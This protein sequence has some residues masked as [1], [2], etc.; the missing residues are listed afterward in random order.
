MKYAYQIS[1]SVFSYEHEDINS[2][3]ESFL[4]FF[5]FNL[6]ENKVILKNTRASGFSDKKIEIFE[7]ALAKDS[8][9]K[10]FINNLLNNLSE[11]QK[12]QLIQQA[13]SRL[14]AELN[15]F[16]RFDK[17]SWIK[18]RKLFLTDSGKCFH[19]KISVAAFPRKREA[20]LKII[21]DLFGK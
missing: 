8:L 18:D 13:G 19:L 5:P 1:L 10:Q 14:D 12:G 21:N 3:L 4:G 2:V 9:I 16:I 6:E 17:D 20:A 11:V 15:F 7:A